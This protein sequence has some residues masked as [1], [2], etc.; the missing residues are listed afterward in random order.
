[1]PRRF[2]RKFAFK[3]HELGDSRLLRPFAKLINEPR[4]W[5]IRRR[6]VVPAFALGLF[7]A[8]L[9]FPGHPV[10]A[11]L[12]ALAV[13]INVP[14]AFVTTFV[15]NPLTM[16][17]MYLAAYHLGTYILDLEPEPFAFEMTLDWF[18]HTFVRYWQPMSLGGVLMG[19][20]AATIGYVVVDIL[21]RLS[22]HE[23]KL[24]KRNKRN[25]GNN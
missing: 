10:W 4:Y 17:P 20:L 18:L 19:A 3:R 16:G 25:N 22:L 12:I 5:G 13:R 6:T 8:F 11:M 7:I 2:F 21:W 23:Y 24:A 14:V 9:P 15:S 1:M